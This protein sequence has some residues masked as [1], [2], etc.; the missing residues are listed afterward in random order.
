M[1]DERAGSD[2]ADQELARDRRRFADSSIA[3]IFPIL[4]NGIWHTTGP[5]AMRS[6][7]ATDQIRPNQREFPYS[8]PQTANSYGFNK[9]YVC[10]FDFGVV[11]EP[12]Y[13]RFYER[14]A[15][16][17]ERQKPFTV[18]IELDRAAL[19]E[20]LVPNDVAKREVG[21]KKVWIPYVEAWH[22]GPISLA[23]CARQYVLIDSP[24]RLPRIT[25]FRAQ[26]S[27]VRRSN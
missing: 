1:T 6:M 17:F 8:F 15:E 9:G 19:G 12:E 26:R 18:A 21:Y 3:R 7:L 14:W 25:R 2:D 16:F 11:A 13:V 5:W 20:K 10:L 24:N 22:I 27:R 4:R 23:S